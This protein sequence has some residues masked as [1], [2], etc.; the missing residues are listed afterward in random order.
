MTSFPS[1]RRLPDLRDP[2]GFRPNSPATATCRARTVARSD[3]D[4]LLRFAGLARGDLRRR[5]RRVVRGAQCRQPGAGVSAG[6]RR[7]WRLGGAGNMRSA[8]WMSDISW[9]WYARCGGIRAFIDKIE[10]LSPGDFIGRWMAMFIKPGEQVSQRDQETMHDFTVR[11][12]KPRC[13]ARS[14]TRRRFRSSARRSSAA[15]SS[16]TAPISASP[17]ARRPCSTRTAKEFRGAGG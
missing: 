10:P 17:K 8:L 7:A 12:R 11:M 14:K 13:S 6:W 2:S 4:R 16:W 1:R 15:R 3:G 5:P 9:C